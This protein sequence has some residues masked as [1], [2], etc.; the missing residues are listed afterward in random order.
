MTNANS[1]CARVLKGRYFPNCEFMDATVP[2]SA[3]ATSRAIVAGHE[4]LF[5]KV[6]QWE[7]IPLQFLY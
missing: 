7:R 3:S 1:L 2:K 4:A 6:E 5:L